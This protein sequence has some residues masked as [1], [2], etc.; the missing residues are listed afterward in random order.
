MRDRADKFTAICVCIISVI[1]MML[2]RPAMAGDS[3]HLPCSNAIIDSLGSVDRSHTIVID[4]EVNPLYCTFDDLNTAITNLRNKVPDTI[5][6][7]RKVGNLDVMNSENWS[8]YRDS[9]EHLLTDKFHDVSSDDHIWMETFFDIADNESANSEILDSLA[10]I[11]RLS[12]G[13]RNAVSAEK[14]LLVS[15]LPYYA[16]AQN[17][18]LNEGAKTTM[19]NINAAVRY[20]FAHAE[21][22]TQNNA[23]YYYSQDCTNF[24][25]QILQA[26]GKATSN[27]WWYSSRYSRSDSWINANAFAQLWGIKSRTVDHRTFSTWVSRG[28]FIGLDYGRDGSCDHIGFVVNK[29]GDVGSYYNYQ[30]A[31]HTSD[32]VDWV[33]SGRNNWE[34]NSTANYLI[35]KV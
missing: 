29:G 35:L 17:A 13:S 32:Y 21:K 26:G 10:M 19:T 27:S 1:A 34:N 7:I 16:P 25:S 4:G 28:D 30:V 2:P 12:P 14:V 6:A 24:A 8:G 33:S 3:D 18:I 9:Y 31:Q 23:F 11:E 20:A 22:N 15:K 5:E